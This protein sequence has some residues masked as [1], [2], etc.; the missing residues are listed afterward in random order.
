MLK[1]S[2]RVFD[3]VSLLLDNWY[4]MGREHFFFSSE[5]CVLISILFEGLYSGE[6][7]YR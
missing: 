5:D 3:S 7:R 1:V 4:K 6:V 2:L